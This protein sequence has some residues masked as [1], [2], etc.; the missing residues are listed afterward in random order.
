M[1]LIIIFHRASLLLQH[2]FIT[3]F[4]SHNYWNNHQ[5]VSNLK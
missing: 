2:C 3:T 5:N 1:I 4:F